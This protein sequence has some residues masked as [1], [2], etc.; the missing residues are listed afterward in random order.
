MTPLPEGRQLSPAVVRELVRNGPPWVTQP[1]LMAA[2]GLLYH[3]YAVP[4][5][6]HEV[7]TQI[8]GYL[9]A[10]WRLSTAAFYGL[11]RSL[12]NSQEAEMGRLRASSPM[13]GA[14]SHLVLLASRRARPDEP[15]PDVDAYIGAVECIRAA[16]TA[17]GVEHP[18]V[19]LQIDRAWRSLLAEDPS[20][21]RVSPAD[22]QQ[23]E[24][25]VAKR[26][27]VAAARAG[28][29][30]HEPHTVREWSTLPIEMESDPDETYLSIGHLLWGMR[31][32]RRHRTAQAFD[33]MAGEA[34]SKGTVGPP[35]ALGAVRGSA[36][37]EECMARLYRISGFSAA[38]MD[39]AAAAAAGEG[40]E[41]APLPPKYRALSMEIE[42]ETAGHFVCKQFSCLDDPRLKEALLQGWE[43]GIVKAA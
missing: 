16:L 18:P 5:T 30:E 38:E 21:P 14:V 41:V 22:V 15:Y 25:C 35:P 9:L 34:C 4:S 8:R 6:D 39:R 37:G 3:R 28:W 33:A 20:E 11:A 17:S 12:L 13:W 19:W 40:A 24:P 27:A 31:K 36:L 1:P 26:L 29:T 2:L 10:Q 43:Q 7:S 42:A 23:L 32:L